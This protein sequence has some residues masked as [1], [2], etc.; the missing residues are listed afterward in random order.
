MTIERRE[1]A[2]SA[3]EREML[4]GWL[5]YHRSTL[6]WKCEGLT[7]AQL[8]TKP[9]EPS[10]LSL[11]GLVRHLSEV[12]RFWFHEV[13]LGE[14]PGTLYCTEEDPDGDFHVTEADTWEKTHATWQAEIEAARGNAAGLSLDDFSRGRSR[15]TGEAFNLRW[16]YTHMIEE[17]ARHNGHADLVRERIDGATGD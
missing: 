1:P 9:L 2:L 17:Y 10:E 6:A 7:D 3:G 13:L 5:D 4:E 12:E 8:R 14:D 16:I 11:L 15:S